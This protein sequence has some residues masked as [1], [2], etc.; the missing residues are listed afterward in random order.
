S[1]LPLS[2][3]LPPHKP[4]RHPLKQT[5]NPPLHLHRM[6]LQLRHLLLQVCILTLQARGTHSPAQ[7]SSLEHLDAALQAARVCEELHISAKEPPVL[8]CSRGQLASET[9]GGV[10]APAIA[11]CLLVVHRHALWDNRWWVRRLDG[12][13]SH[14]RSNWHWWMARSRHLFLIP[15]RV[16]QWSEYERRQ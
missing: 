5:T 12:G 15:C 11:S 14:A 4:C 9:A 3:N 1:S 8:E 7:V 2:P 6:P 16:Q 13:G 10:V